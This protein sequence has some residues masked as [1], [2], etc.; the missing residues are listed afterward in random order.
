MKLSFTS[1]NIFIQDGNFDDFK[2]GDNFS[3]NLSIKIKENFIALKNHSSTSITNIKDN[4]YEIVCR[5][6]RVEDDVI[7]VESKGLCFTIEPDAHLLFENGY[8]SF[9]G[10]IYHDIW[11]S[12]TLDEELYEKYYKELNI[13][14]K[15]LSIKI[16]TSKPIKVSQK[17]YT[18]IGKEPSYSI[19]L[20]KT[21]AWKDEKYTDGHSFNYLLEMEIFE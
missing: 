5:V 6:Y 9:V 15:I 13:S 12:L 20:E 2:L 1:L 10:T 17:E 14:G 7:F 3:D 4:I 8:Y 16:D 21:S 11:N 19:S 18:Q